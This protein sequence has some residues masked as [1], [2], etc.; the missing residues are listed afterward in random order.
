MR[1]DLLKIIIDYLVYQFQNRVDMSNK[2]NV[3]LTLSRLKTVIL[4]P[5]V[6][7]LGLKTKYILFSGVE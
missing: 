1:Y 4:F 2:K 5:D 7:I 6:K 3:L